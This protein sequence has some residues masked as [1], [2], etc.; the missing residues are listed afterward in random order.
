MHCH[1]S[2]GLAMSRHSCIGTCLVY[3]L[4]PELSA[5][6]VPLLKC[7]LWLLHAL[8]KEGSTID[9]IHITVTAMSPPLLASPL[10]LHSSIGYTVFILDYLLSWVHR[11]SVP[12]C[13][14]CMP[15][16]WTSN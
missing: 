5:V 12:Y 3:G 4:H 8:G 2:V 7:S 11:W 14:R 6:V 9:A 13:Y 1:C 15:S 10:Y 16:P